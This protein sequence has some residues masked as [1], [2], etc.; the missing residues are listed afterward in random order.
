MKT[1]LRR[2][3]FLAISVGTALGVAACRGSQGGE[4]ADPVGVSERV[5]GPL[6][7]A[8]AT[9]GPLGSG[10]VVTGTLEPAVRIEVKA[11]VPGT[12]GRVR[13]DRGDRVTQRQTLAVITAAGIRSAAAS[14]ES[15]V[16]S[17][18]AGLALAERQLESATLLHEAG[19]LSDLEF[20]Q[21]KTGHEAAKA[22]VAAA[23]AGLAGAREQ[24]QRATVRAPVTGYISDRTAETGEAVNPGQVL[25]T[26]VD[27]TKL[28]LQ[29]QV[30]VSDVAQVQ[31]GQ[32]VV[33]TL[34]AMP[35][36]DFRGS[37][38]RIEPTADPE[39][40]QVGVYLQLE[41]PGNLVGGLFARGRILSRHIEDALLVP[42][43][44][45]RQEG[46]ETFVLFIQEGKVH[47]APVT[48]IGRDEGLGLVGVDGPL[49]A[50]AVV[51][52]SPARDIEEGMAVRL[53]GSSE[54][55]PAAGTE[56]AHE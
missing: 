45:L 48:V 50:G 12:L 14:A 8:E 42:A 28:E 26:V 1:N 11:Q 23:E 6:D 33:F 22:Q 17:A 15:G 21:A 56:D 39:T 47:R 20:E 2:V 27:I 30:S 38:A 41:N 7:V 9:R 40:R 51:L 10:V 4:A 37:V 19:A 44:A 16:A 29:A 36:Q 52:I 32:E 54:V 53:A 49:D 55:P 46:P 18:R 25:F 3:C 24:A 35:G 5:L 31:A 13:V 34:D 43:Q